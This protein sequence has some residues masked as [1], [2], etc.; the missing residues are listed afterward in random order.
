MVYTKYFSVVKV[1]TW[2]RDHLDMTPIV[3]A[4][5]PNPIYM[6]YKIIYYV[7]LKLPVIMVRRP[8]FN[9]QGVGTGVF[10]K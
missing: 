4:V 3:S 7:G 2:L 10:L 5:F 6:T 8:T 1:L 9:L